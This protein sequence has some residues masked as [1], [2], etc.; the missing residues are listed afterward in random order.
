MENDTKNE[1]GSQIELTQGAKRAIFAGLLAIAVREELTHSD[2]GVTVNVRAVSGPE[3][4]DRVLQIGTMRMT[5]EGADPERVAAWARACE[6]A[7]DAFLA[8]LE[9]SS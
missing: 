9:C 8:A 7:V 4:E 5:V 3:P 1:C 2:G 6:G